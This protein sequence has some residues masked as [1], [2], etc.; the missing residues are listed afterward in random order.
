MAL[1]KNTIFA[2]AVLLASSSQVFGH[3][4]I[5][6]VTGANGVK[7]AGFG[8]I[9]STPRDGS[10]RRPFQQDTSVIDDKDISRGRTGVC[11]KTLAGGNNDVQ[12]Q[13]TAAVNAGLPTTDANG[14]L[15]MTLHQINGDGAG[16]YTCDV[17]TD[18]G[19]TF[20]PATVATNV[21]GEN[22]R[23]R[24]RAQDF[25]LVMQVSTTMVCKGGPNGDACIA[26][27]RNPARA[28]PFGACVAFAMGTEDSNATSTAANSTVASATAT[29]GTDAASA[30]SAADTET[31]AVEDDSEDEDDEEVDGT[32]ANAVG[33][34]ADV[35]D[36]R[37]AATNAKSTPVRRV[38]NS[39]IVG[40]AAAWINI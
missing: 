13:L 36:D 39:R 35:G 11:G 28:G 38:I 21:P 22:G 24:A 10:R 37:A 25:P 26:R 31:V 20:T 19:A 18:G 5:T 15:A 12:A 2:L 16:P 9:A 34:A 7:A 32:A 27:C 4:A 3:G 23:S 40:R 29:N 14:Q 17:S 30:T 8:I 6:A 1:L 33:N